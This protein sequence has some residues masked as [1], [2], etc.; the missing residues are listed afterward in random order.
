MPKVSRESLL[1]FLR[2]G[3]GKT[4][5]ELCARFGVSQPTMSRL[6]SSLKD[7]VIPVGRGPRSRYFSLNGP[8]DVPVFCVNERGACSPIGHLSVLD[9]GFFFESGSTMPALLGNEFRDGL[10]DALPW[11]IHEMRPQGYLGR[12][13]ARSIYGEEGF[14]RTL[15]D[16][17]DNTILRYLLQYGG[18]EPGALIVGERARERF[19]SSQANVIPERVRENSYERLAEIMLTGGIPGSSA[20]GKQPKFCAAIENAS[21]SIR[22]VIV[23]FSGNRDIP[24]EMRRADLLIAEFWAGEALRE[25]GFPVPAAE[26]VFAGNRCFLESTRIDRIGEFGRRW[27]CSLAAI[28]PAFIGSG[29]P[30]WSGMVR[31]GERMGV[32][33]RETLEKVIAL[34][35]FGRAI[36]NDDMHW[37][38]LSFV[39]SAAFPFELAPIYD[40]SPMAYRV[41]GDSSFPTTSLTHRA[42]DAQS[43]AML[44]KFRAYV[45][46]DARISPGFREIMKTLR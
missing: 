29:S 10:F 32:F 23:K 44:Q 31:A 36:G 40:M 2:T 7:T 4:S 21:G 15:T 35:N 6:L 24:A 18:D 30:S 27:T 5:R 43:E 11:F 25:F 26:L 9:G 22:H 46:G 20:A 37:G 39:V 14:S 19:L 42:P 8:K 3:G 16:W 28:E 33:S 41:R 17:D 13:I 34:E 12:A 1:T 38:N 45:V